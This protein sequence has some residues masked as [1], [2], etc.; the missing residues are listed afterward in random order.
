M[1]KRHYPRQRNTGLNNAKRKSFP[2]IINAALL[3]AL[4]FSHILS[5]CNCAKLRDRSARLWRDFWAH[6]RIIAARLS[7]IRDE[8]TMISPKR[9]RA[10]SRAR[11]A[12][13]KCEWRAFRFFF[14]FDIC[15]VF[16][17]DVWIYVC[18]CVMVSFRIAFLRNA[19]NSRIRD[20][21]AITR[22]RFINFDALFALHTLLLFF[23][24]VV[25]KS[26][27]YIK[28]LMNIITFRSMFSFK[29][30]IT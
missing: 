23:A 13:T 3:C 4:C 20:P 22:S 21:E 28:Y 19:I 10:F 11:R 7:P 12:N 15:R 24:V 6:R 18:V 17:F 29:I 26:I 1:A 27:F 9:S 5:W 2:M 16:Q 8:K 30:N 14:V 25:F